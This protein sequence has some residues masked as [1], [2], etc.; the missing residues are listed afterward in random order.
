MMAALALKLT[1]APVTPALSAAAR[2]L[3]YPVGSGTHAIALL[4]PVVV[5]GIPIFDTAMVT[6]SRLRRGVPVSRGGRDHTSH[7]L[8]LAGLSQ[9]EA[10]M[11]LYL[12]SCALGGISIM[13]TH[14][15]IT[16]GLS[17]VIVLFAAAVALFVR[18]ERIYAAPAKQEGEISAH[19][20]DIRV[21]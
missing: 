14:A 17:V 6:I 7:R 3:G 4:A 2:Q 16:E 18:L 10:V 13:L 8:V 21:R 5:L 9:R 15:T 12:A 11:T 19:P 1:L 20:A